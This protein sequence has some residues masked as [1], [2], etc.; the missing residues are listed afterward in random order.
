MSRLRFQ[1]ASSM[2]VSFWCSR[3]RIQ[4]L[5]RTIAFCLF[6]RIEINEEIENI[7]KNTSPAPADKLLESMYYIKVAFN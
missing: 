4:Q 2:Q 3:N 6:M 1:M 7:H 5:Q